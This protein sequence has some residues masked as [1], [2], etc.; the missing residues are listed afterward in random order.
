MLLLAFW[1]FLGAQVQAQSYT[2]KVLA[3][4]PELEVGKVYTG[5]DV[6]ATKKLFPDGVAIGDET[7][8][9]VA[10]LTGRRAVVIFYFRKQ[11][12]ADIMYP[13]SQIHI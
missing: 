8:Y 4:V 9:P 12:S 11:Y 3:T 10:K 5:K 1:A 7:V 2:K 13:F 6:L